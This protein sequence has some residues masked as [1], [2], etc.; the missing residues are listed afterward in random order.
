MYI[1][2]L[3]Y[4]LSLTGFFYRCWFRISILLDKIKFWFPYYIYF[5]FSWANIDVSNC[6]FLNY[7]LVLPSTISNS[8]RSSSQFYFQD[9]LYSCYPKYF[10]VCVFSSTLHRYELRLSHTCFVVL[11]KACLRASFIIE[12][13]VLDLSSLEFQ[14]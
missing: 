5:F 2:S 8:T 7:Y 12:S 13:F 11:Q 6:L 1:F 9:L 14:V 10:L 4:F 3:R